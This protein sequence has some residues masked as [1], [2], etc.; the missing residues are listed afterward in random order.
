MAE[1]KSY[2]SFQDFSNSI[3]REWRYT[4]SAEQEE[5][6]ATLLETSH[7]R[8]E[9]IPEGLVL[10]RAQRGADWSS[11]DEED[12]PHPFSPERMKP[13][14]YKSS[15]GRA[16]PKGIPLLYAA[17]HHD[18]AIAEMRPW[19]GA[20][21]SVAEL[22]VSRPLTVIK[23]V[24][25][26]RR[27]ILYGSEPDAPERERKVWQDIDY[28]FS[29]PIVPDEQPVGYVPTQALA[30]FFRHHGLDGV[31]YR[32]SLGEGHNLALFDLNSATIV[33]GC[34]F[35]VRSVKF[36]SIEASNPYSVSRK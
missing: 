36:T 21:V 11:Q 25:E 26:N 30:E 5:F 8:R 2:L 9:Q 10:W 15:E 31:A 18:T 34:L 19:I 4:R 6:L 32:S 24:S 35:Q 29:K 28:A 13:L 23:C 16:N 22:R 27:L 17:T 12:G 3:S 33:G 1:F 7:S 14:I 20:F